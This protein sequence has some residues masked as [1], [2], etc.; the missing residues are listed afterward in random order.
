MD[1]PLFKLSPQAQREWL[2]ERLTAISRDPAPG[3][4]LTS[5]QVGFALDESRYDS[6]EGTLAMLTDALNAFTSAPPD[7]L[8]GRRVTGAEMTALIAVSSQV[9]ATLAWPFEGPDAG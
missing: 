7:P 9:K 3:P 2:V 1:L 6:G 4:R 8:V 5:R